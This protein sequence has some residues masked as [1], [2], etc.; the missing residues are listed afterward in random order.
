MF[1]RYLGFLPFF[2][3]NFKTLGF[4]TN[5][6]TSASFSENILTSAVAQLPLPITPTFENFDILNQ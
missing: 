6:K 2:F 3:I 4:L 1:V 5:H